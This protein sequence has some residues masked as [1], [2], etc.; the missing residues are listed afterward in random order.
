MGHKEYNL[1][2]PK[3]ANAKQACKHL[4]D[5]ESLWFTQWESTNMKFMGFVG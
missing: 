1:D 5:L 2:R 3:Q 4:G